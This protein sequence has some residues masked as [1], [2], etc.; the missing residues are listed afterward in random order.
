[1]LVQI[2]RTHH[3]VKP[4]GSFR[5]QYL[6]IGI[7]RCKFRNYSVG[8]FGHISFID[9][10]SVGFKVFLIGLPVAHV[11]ERLRVQHPVVRPRYLDGSG[12]R[13]CDP[14]LVFPS[15]LGSDEDDSVSGPGA[16]DG[17]GG[18]ILQ[19]RNRLYVIRV[20]GRKYI[21]RSAFGI[22]ISGRQGVGGRH[23]K[24]VDYEKRVIACS[25]RG[26]TADIERGTSARLG[27]HLGDAQSGSLSGKGVR[28][29]GHRRSL[30]IIHFHYRHRSSEGLLGLGTVSDNH[31]LVQHLGVLLH[32]DIQLVPCPYRDIDSHESEIGYFKNGSCPDLNA[33]TSVHVSDG[34]DT[35]NSLDCDIGPDNRYSCRVGHHSGDCL[36]FARIGR[37]DLTADDY[38]PAPD[39]VFKVCSGKHGIEHCRNI[40]Y[41]QF[42][43]DL[44]VQIDIGP[45]DENVSA[46]LFYPADYFPDRQKLFPADYRR[47][48]MLCPH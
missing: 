46:V 3:L 7:Y 10:E 2:A 12:S 47:S 24:T 26:C 17:R 18:S 29:R 23:R 39:A 31:D 44:S 4:V 28:H 6:V 36:L 21:V 42:D 27:G 16:V 19:H 33:E 43:A 38:L 32:Y 9:I 34:S 41:L 5:I 25:R 48:V 35:G 11:H 15:P 37:D 40:V 13:V 30:Q 22:D 20:D 8:R 14:R 45:V 1:M